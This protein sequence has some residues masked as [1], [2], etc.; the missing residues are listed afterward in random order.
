MTGLEIGFITLA[1]MLL[2]IW[3]GLHVA[4]ALGLTSFVGVW[5]I[6]D[7]PEV[8]VSMLAQGASD[9]IASY[10]FGVVPLFVLMGFLVSIAD[11]GKDA[12]EVA[13]QGLR[14]LRGGLGIATV[15]ANA[16]FAAITGISIASAAVFTRVAVPE[17]LRYGY[18]PRFATGV[19]AGSSV[20]GMLIPPSLLMILYGFLSEV[21]VGAM[22]MAGIVPGLLLAITYSVGI[23][24][25]ARFW[26]SYVG[27]SCGG[28][29]DDLQLM[30]VGEMAAKLLPIIILVIAVL[31][32][33]Y[34]GFFNATDAGA[35]GAAGALLIALFKRKLDSR[36]LWQVL[37]ETGHVTVAVSFLIIGASLY[38]R[39]LALSGVP[40]FLVEEIVAAGFGPLGFLAIYIVL[41]V[42]LGCFIDSSSIL[43]IVLPLMLP[44]ASG[45]D[46][47]LIWFG[48]ITIVAVEIGLLTPPF[49][50]SV[51]VIK[52]TL[53]D[54]R[55][56]L[57]DIFI[58]TLPFVTIMLLTLA[59]LVVFPGLTL[60]L[61]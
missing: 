30:G 21:S 58:G 61:L 3:L 57:R 11:I 41:I 17:M 40:Q 28:E 6:K 39:M 48:I 44:I 9:S 37:V 13:N 10:I 32:G 55:I 26:P 16:I 5:L 22:F 38:T 34:A 36:K 49:G 8:A 47:N 53:N 33:I 43:L 31:G 45:F 24:L 1:G 42:L 29:A 20:L 23:M 56:T 50:L 4:V 54:S 14:R 2:L 12:F 7:S 46:M 59:A 27:G 18:T 35:V 15:A 19:V 60:A 25:M 51:F 52:S